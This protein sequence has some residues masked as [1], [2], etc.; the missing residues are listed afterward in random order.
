M[1]KAVVM[2]ACVLAFVGLFGSFVDAEVKPHALF[3]DK[4]VLQRNVAVPV[5]GT[6]APGER[7]TVEF[8]RQ[9][10][11]VAAGPDG[12]WLVRLRPLRA[13]GPHRMMISGQNKIE[14]RDVLIGE[15]WLCSGQSNM[16][17]PLAQTAD[18]EREI[19]NANHP[20][21]R[22]F[23]VPK[24]PTSTPQNTVDA[25]W[26]ETLPQTAAEFSAVGYYFARA[27]QRNLGVPIGLIDSSYGGTA[28]EAWT[29]EE[30]LRR[31]PQL[32]GVFAR[33]EEALRVLPEAQ[34]RY[35]QYLEDQRRYETAARTAKENGATA[36]TPPAWQQQPP[37]PN[38][39][40]S[41]S[42]LFN[43]M[44]A[45]LIPYA[46]RGAIWYQ[47]ESN[48]G[49]AF[50]YRT[51]F[52]AM[53]RDWRAR[54]KQED[55]D[56]PFLFV[57]LAPFM[58]IEREPGESNWAELREA[59]LLTVSRVPQTAMA[60]I[61][62]V[63]EED[64]IHPQRKAPVGERLALAARA[65]AYGEKI[66]YSGPVYASMKIVGERAVLGFTHAGRG[67]EMHGDK[68]QGFT[69]AG[70]DRKFANAEARIEG[71][72]IIVE[73]PQVKQPVAVRYGWANY[74]VTNLR[75]KDGLPA[76]PFRTDDWPMLTEPKSD[77]ATRTR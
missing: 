10:V 75:N 15:V 45:P 72:K 21:I 37:G 67:L 29:S 39:P 70:P 41:P 77:Q 19:P 59:Q 7:V 57:Q 20:S 23:T 48:A 13:G 33:Y 36:S 3:S 52:P 9:K 73:S 71:D 17:W 5:W 74:P 40:T 76:T 38:S 61:T 44:I 12:T 50:E 8:E 2:L 6:A 63:G 58:K 25:A 42:H 56:F 66:E 4:M 53:I 11:S 24:R 32:R 16:E 31:E 69:I 18:A 65:L 49:R 43:G 64:D 27:L 34:R 1:R 55:G 14:L 46:M 62:D 68:L 30:A 51:L 54:W 26:E 22:L 35:E 47:G 60:V 28:A